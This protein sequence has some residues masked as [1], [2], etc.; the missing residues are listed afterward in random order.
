MGRV[1]GPVSALRFTSHV[2]LF[3]QPAQHF[4][5]MKNIGSM[6]LAAAMASAVC[7]PGPTQAAQYAESKKVNPSRLYDI[8]ADGAKQINE[9]LAAAKK[10]NK[11]VFLQFGANWCSWCH[12]MH[13]L[14][15]TDKPIAAELKSGYVVVLIDVNK[16]HNKSVD[17][18]YGQP[19]RLGLPAIV[20]L[21][22]DGHQLTTKDST[23]L[24]EGDHHSPQKVLAF[25]KQWAPVRAPAPAEGQHGFQK[26]GTS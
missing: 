6:L 5:V 10:G 14:F 12:K 19:T 20:I 22:A 18:K 8:N 13:Q 3:P 2:L 9:A 15:E 1:T 16:E 11:R 25:L 21:D 17:L 26:P 24:E 4:P 23:D 7:Q